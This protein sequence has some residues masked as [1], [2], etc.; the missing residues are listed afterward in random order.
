[1]LVSNKSQILPSK[2]LQ[3]HVH[4][5]YRSTTFQFILAGT[6]G[7]EVNMISSS[8]AVPTHLYKHCH[9]LVANGST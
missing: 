2:L 1:M 9:Q 4:F 6:K 3:E 8:K 7:H 5:D